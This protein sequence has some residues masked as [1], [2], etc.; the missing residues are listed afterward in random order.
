MLSQYVEKTPNSFL[1]FRV[2]TVFD[3][4]GSFAVLGRFTYEH[5]SFFAGFVVGTVTHHTSFCSS[6][7]ARDVTHSVF[8]QSEIFMIRG[9]HRV[10]FARLVGSVCDTLW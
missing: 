7:L 3:T 2:V 4:Q 10:A 8:L 1:K 6:G 9:T 5:Q